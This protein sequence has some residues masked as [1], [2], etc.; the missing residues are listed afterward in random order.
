MYIKVLSGIYLR[1]KLRL[2]CVWWSRN[3]MF[4]SFSV[5]LHCMCASIPDS[6]ITLHNLQN[7]SFSFSVLF[8]Q[9]VKIKN[10]NTRTNVFPVVTF[11]PGENSEYSTFLFNMVRSWILRWRDTV[12]VTIAKSNIDVTDR[13]CS[14]DFKWTNHIIALFV[15]CISNENRVRG[16]ENSNFFFYLKKI[17]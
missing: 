3:Q 7:V 15:Y 1:R 9:I 10:K 12:T 6:E 4:I 8:S 2:S 16:L 17:F 5:L 11:F 14:H 13:H